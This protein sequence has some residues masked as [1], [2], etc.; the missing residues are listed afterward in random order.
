MGGAPIMWAWIS[1]LFFRWYRESEAASDE[2][3][4]APPRPDA[5]A[6]PRR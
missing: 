3:D 1:I 5:L 6:Q 4:T 2:P